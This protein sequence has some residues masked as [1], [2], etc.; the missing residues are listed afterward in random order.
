MKK[1]KKLLIRIQITLLQLFFGRSIRKFFLKPLEYELVSV[2]DVNT[3]AL[4]TYIEVLEFIQVDINTYFT[5]HSGVSARQTMRRMLDFTGHKLESL[6]K[7]N[8]ELK[9]LKAED[10]NDT[11]I[12]KD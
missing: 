2:I 8:D 7:M 9:D 3:A 6:K 11:E 4:S 1:L 10:K 12:S 5:P